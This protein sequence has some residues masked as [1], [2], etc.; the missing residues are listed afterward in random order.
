MTE[1]ESGPRWRLSLI[2]FLAT[3]FT[4]TATGALA[5][6]QESMFPLSDGLAYS[7]PLMA[8]LLCH[9]FGHYFV[10]RIHGVPASLPFFVPLPPGFGILGT[11]GAVIL[12][13]GTADR[14]KLFDIGVAGPLA[15]LAVAIPALVYGLTLSDVKPLM[16][17]G[18]QEGNS[19]LYALLKFTLKGQWLPGNGHDVILHPTAFAGW[20]GLLVTM[21][22][23]MPIGQLDGG[24]AAAAYFGNRYESAARILHR[25]LPALAVS[26]FA[27]VFVLISRDLGGR[28][29]P[30][31]LSEVAIAV[32]PGLM[33]LTWFVL[34]WFLKRAAQG[35]YH[36]LVDDQPLPTNRAV[37]FWVVAIIFVL[38]FMPIPM[39]FSVGA[40]LPI[41]MLR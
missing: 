35:R 14:K 23:L 34:L 2:L 16:G 32:G 8:I 20:A 17:I 6:H 38:I 29:L 15:G 3:C 13:G 40:D 7:V 37:M 4:T 22:N 12:Q 24:H 33:W 18:Q 28:E 19:I 1:D 31:G 41:E 21:L 26:V 36:P 10:A 5:L 39:R 25:T 27:W 11:M 30:D 9:E